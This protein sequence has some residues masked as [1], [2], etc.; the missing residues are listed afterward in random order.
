M[1]NKRFKAKI[2]SKILLG[3]AVLGCA[4][5]V[6]MFIRDREQFAFGYLTSFAFFICLALGAVLFV[7]IHHLTRAGWSVVVRRI[8]ENIAS[9]LQWMWILAVP[10][11]V[12]N[13]HDL[14]HWSHSEAIANDPI[15][16]SKSA[17]FE[18]WFFIL[19]ACIYFSVWY[20]TSWLLLKKSVKQDKTGDK[21]LTLFLQKWSAPGLILYVITETFFAFDWIMSLNP[22]WF[23]T[24]FGVYFFSCSAMGIM[25]LLIIVAMVLRRMGY[26]RDVIT[27]EHYH[28]LGKYLFGFNMFWAYI[29]FCQFL[30]IW[31]AN[32]G[33]E[34][35]FF[36]MRAVGSWKSLSV[37]IP[38]IHFAIPFFFMISRNVK[39]NLPAL[40]ISALWLF[41]VN[42]IDIF[43]LIMPNH[44][45]E[46]IEFGIAEASG[47]L[48]I[49]SL[50]FYFLVKKMEESSLVPEKDPRLDESLKFENA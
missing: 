9:N 18:T 4:G 44:N 32:L 29:A 20:I 45:R 28:D 2:T 39:R 13:M 14:F 11:L 8:A 25:A 37:A 48:F 34:T 42:Y 7:L 30:L 1:E 3:L 15:L 12:F 26:L 33:E 16:Q 10:L 36:H 24:I 5:C 31:Y 23:S 22:H 21:N 50:F 27:V 49:G 40:F 35:P 47:L 41:V 6:L 46:G 17:Y 43:W 19:R 38:I